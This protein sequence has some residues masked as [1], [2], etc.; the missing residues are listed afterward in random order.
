V[1]VSPLFRAIVLIAEFIEAAELKE[2]PIEPNQSADQVR[3]TPHD[4][5]K[6]FCWTTVDLSNPDEVRR[7]D[8]RS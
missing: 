1:P 4:L 7:P 6:D 8:A 5:H 3:Q 2:G